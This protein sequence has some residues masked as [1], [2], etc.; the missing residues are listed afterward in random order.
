[1]KHTVFLMA[2]ALAA[3]SSSPK[4]A[5]HEPTTGT[6][7]EGEGK[8]E[9]FTIGAFKAYAL[10]D[11]TFKI[12]PEM[13][14]WPE[15]EAELGPVLSA[16]GLPTDHVE[17]S[18][19]PLLVKTDGHVLLFDTGTGGAFPGTGFLPQSLQLAGVPASEVTDIFISH[20]HGDHVGGLVGKDGA[21][22]F[23]AATIHISAQEWDAMQA[24]DESKTIASAVASKVATFEPGAQILPEV[25]AV[26]TQGHTVG[27]SSYEIVSGADKLFYLGDVAHHST[28][29]LQHPAWTISFDGDKDAGRAMREK[30]LAALAADGERVFAVHFPYP[31]IGK[32]VKEGDGMVWV[33]D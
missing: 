1:M 11:G 12:P 30:T 5:K 7:G 32:V 29:S 6:A 17:L 10:R 27:H 15:N 2:A 19:T 26:A 3:C 20:A 22:A 16:A 8:A 33:A 28:V 21:P 13:K 23:P 31:G 4:Q 25:R 9:P 14:L 18:I 24:S